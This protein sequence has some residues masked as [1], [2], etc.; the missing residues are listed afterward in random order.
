MRLIRVSMPMMTYRPL[1][2]TSSMRRL[3]HSDIDPIVPMF[4]LDKSNKK[5]VNKSNFW[6]C[7]FR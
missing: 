6:V 5:I 7:V 3:V 1:L 2:E 4:F